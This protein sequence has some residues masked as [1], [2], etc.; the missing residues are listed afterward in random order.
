MNGK[1]AALLFVA[2]CV[3]LALLLVTGLIG[4]LL[5]GA[6][7]AVALIALGTVSGGFRKQDKS[8]TG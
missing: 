3:I 2:V 5:S 4:P 1:T 6:L 7:F 8:S